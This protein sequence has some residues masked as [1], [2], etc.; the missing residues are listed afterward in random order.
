MGRQQQKRIEELEAEV[1]SLQNE[2]NRLNQ[3]K[4]GL[5]TQL[6]QITKE[7]DEAVAAGVEKDNQITVLNAQIENLNNLIEAKNNEIGD[8]HAQIAA[9]QGDTEIVELLVDALDKINQRGV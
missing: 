8:L 5:V 2:I 1:V 6:S 3:E 9:M 4:A 7:R